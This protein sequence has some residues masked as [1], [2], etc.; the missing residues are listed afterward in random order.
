MTSRRLGESE[1]LFS[2]R[3]SPPSPSAAARLLVLV[4][5]VVT[6]GADGDEGLLA[7]V[8]LED[9][10][11]AVRALPPASQGLDESMTLSP[12]GTLGTSWF[13]YRCLA[14]RVETVDLQGGDSVNV[15]FAP[16]KSTPEFR[17]NTIWI[18]LSGHKIVN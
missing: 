2:E 12:E 10:P 8:A 13:L 3:G 18:I 16:T 7:L 6:E 11:A 5:H 4:D 14:L 15:Y 17:K 1:A 9:R